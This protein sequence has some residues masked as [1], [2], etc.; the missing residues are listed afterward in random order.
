MAGEQAEFANGWTRPAPTIND[1]AA[2]RYHL[3]TEQAGRLG[4][5]AGVRRIEPFHFSPRYAGQE[6]RLRQEVEEAFNGPAP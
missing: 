1:R 6:A 2:D 3:T 4:R 5:L